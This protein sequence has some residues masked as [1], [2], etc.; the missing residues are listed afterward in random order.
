MTEETKPEGSD[1]RTRVVP[2]TAPLDD[3]ATVITSGQPTRTSS[4]LFAPTNPPTNPT[5]GPSQAGTHEAG[6]LPV[7]SRLA[8]F[9]ITRVIG[10]GGFGVVNIAVAASPADAAEHAKINNECRELETKAAK[11]IQRAFTRGKLLV[12]KTL[13]M[14]KTV[15]EGSREREG[16]YKDVLEDFKKEKAAFALIEEREH[17]RELNKSNYVIQLIRSDMC[18][19]VPPY[20]PT[21]VFNYARGGDL[22]HAVRVRRV[23]PHPR[24]A[25]QSSPLIL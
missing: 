16:T 5:T 13:D 14:P 8:E 21:L 3:S 10:Q 2:R 9:E 25:S 22:E 19:D 18:E 17:E 11:L 12:I 6:L 20:L 4:P 24:S 23:Q 1:D 7:G 15:G